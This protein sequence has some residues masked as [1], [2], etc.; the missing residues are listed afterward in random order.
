MVRALLELGADRSL[1]DH[2]DDAT[3]LEWALFAGPTEVAELL[4]Q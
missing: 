3:P 2:D 4:S 1:R